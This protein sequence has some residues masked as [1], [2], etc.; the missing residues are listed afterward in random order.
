M[1][2]TTQKTIS[3]DT[4]GA[5]AVNLRKTHPGHVDLIKRFDKA[6]LALSKRGL[7]GIRAQ[8]ALVLDHSISMSEDYRN[9]KVQTLVERVL[10][11]ALQIDADGVVPVIPFDSYV[12]PVVHVGVDAGMTADGTRVVE[13]RDA[14]NRHLWRPRTMGSTDLA[15]ALDV[16]LDMARTASTP[17]FVV[18]ITDGSPDSHSR[19]TR[20]VIE[21]AQYPIFLKFVAIRDVPYLRELDNMGTSRLL[22]NVDAKTFTDP[23]AVTD[24]VFADAMADEWDTWITQARSAGVLR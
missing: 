17:L 21:S 4:D 2:V 15:A 6:G 16:V 18:V 13:Y 5:P 20:R 9:G 24:L 1:T 7:A 11:F 23:A 14:V 8:A 3:F 10:G 19:A 22:D 12:Y